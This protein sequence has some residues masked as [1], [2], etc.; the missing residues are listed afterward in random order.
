MTKK[1]KVKAFITKENISKIKSLT[2]ETRDR[3][4]IRKRE[5]F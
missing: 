1:E 2:E 5:Y 4:G 3:A